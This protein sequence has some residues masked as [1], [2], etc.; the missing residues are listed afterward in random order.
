M[1]AHAEATGWDRLLEAYAPLPGRADELVDADRRV[2][3]HW[4][5]VLAELGRAGPEL[6]AE[7]FDEADRHLRRFGRV[8]PPLRFARRQRAHLAPRPCASRAVVGR[9]EVDRGGH[10][11]ARHPRSSASSP[12]STA[13]RSLVRDGALPAT[14]IAGNPDFLRPLVGVTPRGGCHV[15]VYGADLGRAPDG[16]WWV[17]GDRTQA[18]SGMGYAVENRLAIS[19]AL[20]SLYRDMHVERLARFFQALRAAL[21]ARS[22][23]ETPRIGLLT[24]GPANETYFEHA[25]LARYLGL[26]LVEGGDLTV[27]D[28]VAYVRTIEGPKRIDVLLRRL[29]AGFADPLELTASSKIG[30]PGLLQA[31]RTGSVTLANSLGAGLMEAR[32]MLAFIPALAAQ[33]P[34]RGPDPAQCRDLVV[35]RRPAPREEVLGR[36][37]ELTTR[38]RLVPPRRRPAGRWHEGRPGPRGARRSPG[39]SRTMPSSSSAQEGSISRR[40]PSGP[41]ASSRRGRSRCVSS[42]CRRRMAGRSCMAASAASPRTTTRRRSRSSEAAA[43]PTSGSAPTRPSRTSRF[44]RSL[45]RCRSGAGSASCRAAPPTTCSGSAATS[46]GPRRRSGWCARF[47]RSASRR[48]TRPASRATACRACSSTGERREDEEIRGDVDDIIREAMDGDG[49]GSL[50]VLVGRRVAHRLRHPRAPVDGGHPRD[51]RPARHVGAER[52]HRFPRRV[53]TG[54]CASSRPCPGSPRRT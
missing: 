47:R 27:Q 40:C 1:L 48:A 51:R 38:A 31:L 2:R 54:R 35:R 7:R 15:I 50:P 22:G 20:P 8:L 21:A 42:R 45:P 43:R 13:R 36:L 16:R 24:P 10:H 53:R 17:L 32:A 33:A 23:R 4:S 28:G 29:D 39:S 12:T 5:P 26:L 3:P 18:P 6:L 19:G 46:S 34:R 25:Y 44:C 9:L 52:R 49:N 41:T 14:V 30:V 37:G 11:P